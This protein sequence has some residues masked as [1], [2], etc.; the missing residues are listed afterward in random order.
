VFNF[1]KSLLFEG[2]LG[3]LMTGLILLIFLKDLRSAIIVV[4]NIPLALLCSLLFLYL[5]GQSINIM[6]LGGLALA[7]GI[8]VDEATV[9]VENIHH[10]LEKGKPVARAALDACLEIATPK[11]LILFSILA[12]FVPALFM[13]G[14]SKSLFLPLSLAVGFAMIASFILS[15]SLVPVLTN[16]FLQKK[17]FLEEANAI[18]KL[19]SI[20]ERIDRSEKRKKWIVSLSLAGLLALV[21]ISFKKMGTEIFPRVDSGLMQLRLRMPVGTRIERT[22]EATKQIL[23]MIDSLAGKDNV[24]ISSS[25]VGL[26]GQSYAINPIFLFTSGPHESVIK[27]NLKKS[28]GISIRPPGRQGFVSKSFQEPSIL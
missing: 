2:L 6:T 3:L 23:G 7:V 19:R 22:E 28:S 25:Y 12:V 15:Q 20:V 24:S 4:I 5:A 21:F 9:T 13:T 27:V 10:H 16:W 11:L 14:V 18:K 17:G 26:H 8:L 1:L